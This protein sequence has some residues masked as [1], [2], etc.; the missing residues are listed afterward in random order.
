MDV[1]TATKQFAYTS[2]S[3]T[4][5]ATF[6]CNYTGCAKAFTATSDYE[7]HVRFCHQFT[8]GNP[9]TA[10]TCAKASVAAALAGQCTK[11]LPNAHWLTL[12]VQEA[13]DAFFQ[14]L[15]MRQNMYACLDPTCKYAP[16]ANA[17]TAI[18]TM[19]PTRSTFAVP[20][21]RLGT[22]SESACVGV[23]M[24]GMRHRHARA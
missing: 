10:Q 3:Q 7:Q 18:P 20:S 19:A 13:H 4:T 24:V 22:G 23:V 17:V 12:H 5:L 14:S 15:A 6:Y 2:S 11:S 21:R 9:G 1:S 8:C 16:R